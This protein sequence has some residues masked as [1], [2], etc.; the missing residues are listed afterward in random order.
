[1]PTA[2]AQERYWRH[3]QTLCELADVRKKTKVRRTDETIEQMIHFVREVEKHFQTFSFPNV[4]SL[5][6][7]SRSL[8]MRVDLRKNSFPNSSLVN[9]HFLKE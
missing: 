3:D 1:M 5:L 7:K 6:D 4:Y 8:E 9:P 2:L